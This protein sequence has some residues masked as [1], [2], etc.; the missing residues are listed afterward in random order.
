MPGADNLAILI[1]L[2]EDHTGITPVNC[3]PLTTGSG[4]SR[5]Y[6]RLAAGDLS[7]IGTVNN[8][9]PENEAFFY[10][11]GHFLE[12]GL[13]VPEVLA[14]NS[15]GEYYL[16]DDLG[17][18]SLYSLMGSGYDPVH[19]PMLQKVLETL[20]QFQVKAAHGLDF[21][22]CYP[23]PEFDPAAALWDLHYCKY[24]F[25]KLSGLDIDELRLEK[26]FRNL[27]DIL[28]GDYPA[29]FMYRDFQS[30]NIM[31]HCDQP[32]FIDYQ[33]GRRGPLLY[34]AA[35]L[36]YQSRLGLPDRV[37]N[38]LT[39]HYLEALAEYIPV[40]AEKFH[41]KVKGFALLRLLQTLGAYGYRGIFER[42]PAFIEPI[43]T[44]IRNTINLIGHL[45]AEMKPVYL[46]S[47]LEDLI[48]QYDRPVYTGKGLTIDI[49]SFSYREGIPGDDSLNG[50]GYVFDCR[51]LPNPHRDILLRPF[52]GKDQV[53]R[54]WLGEK[55]EVMAFLDHC[56]ALVMASAT[57]YLTRGFNHLQVNF[58]CTGGKHR[59][60]FC[61]EELSTRLA[62]SGLS[63]SVEVFHHVISG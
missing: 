19:N 25:L 13:P 20:V 16:Q 7:Y 24:M 11:T 35:S 10:L 27:V 63:L 53:I 61:A 58:G 34:D 17:D 48:P 37:R 56:Q 26:E 47:L 8:N 62:A 45:P 14:K 44:G 55:P 28:F 22:R 21:S 1:Q 31:I 4:S 3:I 43:A 2:F 5:R 6:Y 52:T 32:W 51:A 29:G 54:D 30:R 59:S 38:A 36:L 60:V 15:N 57:Q 33:G 9:L 42:K 12:H 50:G 41:L 46:A 23:L 39:D 49:R 40:D 18:V